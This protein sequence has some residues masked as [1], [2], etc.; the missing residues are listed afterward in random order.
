MLEGRRTIQPCL[1]VVAT[2]IDASMIGTTRRFLFADGEIM[3][4][5]RKSVEIAVNYA[6]GRFVRQG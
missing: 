1:K 6:V 5:C 4:N 2:P 3:T